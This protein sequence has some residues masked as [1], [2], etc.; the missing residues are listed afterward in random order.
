[1]ATPQIIDLKAVFS[2]SPIIYS[3]LAMMSVASMGIWLYSLITFRPKDIMP[4]NFRKEL[5][6]L[7]EQE[8]YDQAQ[9]LCQSKENVLSALMKTGLITRQ[10]GAQV[11]IDAMKSEGK[12]AASAF[13]QRLSLLND[14]V[15]VAPM[16][17]LLGTVIGMFYAF[18]DVNRSIESINALFD[19]LGIA[20]GT[21]VM[22]LIV[23]ILSMIFHTTLKYRVVRTLS[24][25]ENEAFTLSSLIRR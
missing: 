11:M 18:Y 6:R 12:R 24:L 4:E 20:V 5:R 17:G 16:L 8:Q 1:M 21:T 25:V 13:W 10:L 7:L 9:K 22:G 3:L 14:I 19:G 2:A 15:I 23:A